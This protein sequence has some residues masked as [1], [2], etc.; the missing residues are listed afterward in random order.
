[1]GRRGSLL[2][3]SYLLCIGCIQSLVEDPLITYEA[4]YQVGMDFYRDKN[5]ENC[6]AFIH[7]SLEDYNF[8]KENSIK[9][10][11]DCKDR[12]S[13]AKYEW[14]VSSNDVKDDM[15]TLKFLEQVAYESNCVKRCFKRVFGDRPEQKNRRVPNRVDEDFENGRPYH[16]LQFCYYQVKT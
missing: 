1:M 16:F 11:L 5:W 13:N 2:V 12:L 7:K 3:F 4:L 15:M 8:Y 6:L 10:R 14:I 9:C